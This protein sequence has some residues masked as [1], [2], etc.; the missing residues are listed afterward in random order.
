MRK[1]LLVSQ[2][3]DSFKRMWVNFSCALC[4]LTERAFLPVL[5]STFTLYL[6]FSSSSLFEDLDLVDCCYS[7]WDNFHL[8]D[9]GVVCDLFGL[10]G[11][12]EC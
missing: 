12:S 11:R 10:D 4:S 3:E 5:N 2:I 8:V 7:I 9:L 1:P 6:Y